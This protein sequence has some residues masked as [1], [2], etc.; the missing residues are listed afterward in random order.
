MTQYLINTKSMLPFEFFQRIYKINSQFHVKELKADNMRIINKPH[1]SN[2]FAY[3][4]DATWISIT[5]RKN[6]LTKIDLN[7]II[8][9]YDLWGLFTC[10]LF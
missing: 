5:V 10:I 1:D 4:G 3:C 2:F 7:I 8:R 6:W 9:K